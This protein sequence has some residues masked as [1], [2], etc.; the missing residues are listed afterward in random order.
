MIV[1]TIV[2]LTCIL[3]KIFELLHVNDAYNIYMIVFW[4]KRFLTTEI[5]WQLILLMI[6][7]QSI[8]AKD[9][10]EHCVYDFDHIYKSCV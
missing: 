6:I 4:V 9:L 10:S 1:C 8:I 2:D 7:F 5:P 3:F